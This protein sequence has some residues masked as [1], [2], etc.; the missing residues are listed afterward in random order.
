MDSPIPKSS[1]LTHLIIASLLRHSENKLH[2]V[3]RV[4]RRHET[5][6]GSAV[7]PVR[8]SGFSHHRMWEKPGGETLEGLKRPHQTHSCESTFR[9]RYYHPQPSLLFQR[10]L[11][12]STASEQPFQ[13]LQVLTVLESLCTWHAVLGTVY[14][15]CFSL[16][17]VHRA[18]TVSKR[19]SLRMD[20]KF[21]VVPFCWTL[22]EQ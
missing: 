8:C 7:W 15:D 3:L 10:T 4:K 19:M 6:Q 13:K 14:V 16:F 1:S 17:A 5:D 21:K 11:S 18:D 20:V 22:L 2:P 12:C 9:Q